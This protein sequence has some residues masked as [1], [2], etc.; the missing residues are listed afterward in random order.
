[1]DLGSADLNFQGHLKYLAIQNM[2][3]QKADEANPSYFFVSRVGEGENMLDIN[4]TW[5]DRTNKQK[6]KNGT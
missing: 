6:Y 4:F 5:V 2:V 1:L 3:D